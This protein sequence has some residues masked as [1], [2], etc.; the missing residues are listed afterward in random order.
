MNLHHRSYQSEDDYGHMR[1]LLVEILG[2]VG[3]PVYAT[4]GDID[5][6][7]SSDDD[8]QAVY[9]THLWFDAE[10]LVAWAWPVDDQVDIVVHPDYPLLHDETLA[11]AE[12]EYRQR[13]GEFPEK[14]MRAWGFTGDA[15]RNATLDA[16]GYRRTD[17]GLV[18]YTQAIERPPDAL[19]LPPGYTFDH[20]RGE[21]NVERRTAVQRA[22]FGSTFMTEAKTRAVQASPTYRPELDLVIVAPD[23]SYAAFTQIWLDETNHVGVF[24]PLGVAADH[25]RRGLGRALIAEGVRRLASYGAQIASV[26]TGLDNTAARALYEAAGFSELDRNI[27]WTKPIGNEQDS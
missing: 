25:R 19:P 12:L 21:A 26:Q 20:V 10:R 4:I 5:W 3:L 2:R 23:D 18:L 22:A 11:W 13:Q 15:V 9:A 7:C 1:R 14:P 17:Q 6:W 16:R 24:E 27:A 8:P